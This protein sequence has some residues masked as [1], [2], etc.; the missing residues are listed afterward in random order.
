MARQVA[1]PEGYFMV[2]GGQFESQASASQL[3]LVLGILSVGTF[4]VLFM[5]FKQANLVLQIMLSIPL[6]LLARS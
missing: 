5:H 2:Y 4:L 3:I 6:P 1:L